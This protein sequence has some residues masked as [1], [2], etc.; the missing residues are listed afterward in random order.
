MSKK[1]HDEDAHEVDP[2]RGKGPRPEHT[3]MAAEEPSHPGQVLADDGGP[4]APEGQ[5][6]GLTPEQADKIEAARGDGEPST[7]PEPGPPPDFTVPD[8]TAPVPEIADPEKARENE[9]EEERERRRR[10]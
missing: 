8:P 10:R 6:H 5:Y 4:A 2:P 9:D 7:P 1:T 3:D